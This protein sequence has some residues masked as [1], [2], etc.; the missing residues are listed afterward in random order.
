MAKRYYSLKDRV[1]FKGRIYGLHDSVLVDDE[2]EMSPE[3]WQ[4]EQAFLD[5]REALRVSRED[6]TIKEKDGLIETLSE[7]NKQLRA[8]NA[9]LEKDLNKALKDLRKLTDEKKDAE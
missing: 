6:K 8:T 9:R 7:D 1:Q 3:I 5:E 4:D 2:Q